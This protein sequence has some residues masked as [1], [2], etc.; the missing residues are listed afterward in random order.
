MPTY[1]RFLQR[2]TAISGRVPE[3]TGLCSGELYLQLAD[4]TIYYR[5]CNQELT[6]V[7]T[8]G[9]ACGQNVIKFS[10]AESGDFPLWNGS[11]FIAYNTGDLASGIQ[12]FSVDLTPYETTGYARTCYVTTGET[13][14]FANSVDLTPYETTGYARTCYVTTG[15]TGSFANSV[16]FTPYETTGYARVCYVTTGETGSFATSSSIFETGNGINS[17]ALKNASNQVIGNYA[18][19]IGSGNIASGNYSQTFGSN[20]ITKQ[21]GEV[22]FSNGKFSEDGDSQYSFVVGR[23]ATTNSSP[24]NILIDGQNSIINLDLKNHIL[25]TANIVGA[26][27]GKYA[28]FELKGM[29]KRSNTESVSFDSVDFANSVSKVIFA[30]TNSSYDVSAIASKVDGSLKIEVVGDASSE[31]RWLAKIDLLKIN[32]IYS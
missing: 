8:D 10:G 7:L 21:Y 2:R 11:N 25:F 23:V 4:E 14:S 5:N 29:I 24:T 30:R 12:A 17:Y 9:Y 18:L 6:T 1:F 16:D 31:M 15:E 26:G 20:I 22:A 28:S 19:A 13:G 3:V 32:S 27:N